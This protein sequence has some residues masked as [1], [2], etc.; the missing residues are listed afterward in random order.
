MFGFVLFQAK[1]LLTIKVPVKVFLLT[2]ILLITAGCQSTSQQKQYNFDKRQA[3]LFYY[4][5]IRT[6]PSDRRA[7][8][9]FTLEN[10]LEVVLVSDPR[11][12]SSAASLTVGTGFYDD[13]NDYQGLAHYLEH[14]VWTSS[15]KFP[16][17]NGFQQLMTENNGRTNAF[18]HPNF[19]HYFFEIDHKK[20]ALTLDMFS[21]AIN[22]PLLDKSYSKKEITAVDEEWRIAKE[23]QYYIN[24]RVNAQTSNPAHPANKFDIGNLST[25][26]D[27]DS[28]T[29]NKK[30]RAFHQKH[31][32]ADEMKLVIASKHSLDELKAF[33]NLYFS[34]FKSPIKSEDSTSST[35]SL[36]AI[37]LPQDY[38][39]HIHVKSKS[40]GE[41]L[42][43]QFP[44]EN[45]SLQWRQ[46]SNYYLY[47]LFNSEQ[48]GT[49]KHT[50]LKQGLISH[51]DIYL[52]PTTYVNSGNAVF[53]MELSE[54]GKK[55]QT[56][57]IE[58]IF[59]YINLMRS[60][61]I[62]QAYFD[63]IKKSLT[64]MW[65]ATAQP[66]I[67]D[68]VNMMSKD[69]QT[70]P[71][72]DALIHRT[73]AISFSE[74]E[75]LAI[76]QQFTPEKMRIWH[77][78]NNEKTDKELTYANGS[79][80]TSAFSPEEISTW[81]NAQVALKLP[82]VQ[83][84]R[85][86][87]T[88]VFTS[89]NRLIAEPKQVYKGASSEAWLANSQ[90][91]TDDSGFFKLQIQTP[92]ALA[93][94][95]NQVM[96]ILINRIYKRKNA[97]LKNRANELHN[98]IVEEGL[99]QFSMTEITLSNATVYHPDILSTLVYN[100]KNLTFTQ[101]ELDRE[102][103]LY[104]SEINSMPRFSPDRRIYFEF[105]RAI[106]SPSLLW[107]S[108]DHLLA[109]SQI[110][111]SDI[112]LFHQKTLK[113][114]YLNTFAFGYYNAESISDMVKESRDILGE[115]QLKELW[116]Y[117]SNFTSSP[118]NNNS[119]NTNISE[120]DVAILDNYIYPHKSKKV[121]VQLNLLN[122]LI[123]QALF[124]RL[125][126][127][128][129]MAYSVYSFQSHVHHYPSISLFLQSGNTELPTIK[130]AFDL[131]LQQYEKEL[132][133]LSP[134]TLTQM[135]NSHIQQINK[136]PHTLVSEASIFEYDW[137]N[138][139]LSFDARQLQIETLEALTKE[140]LIELYQTLFLSPQS[141]KMTLQVKGV[142]FK[143]TQ[144][145]KV[146]N[147]SASK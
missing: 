31:Y 40:V 124:K 129:E 90:F 30:L 48:P 108:E 119:F 18:T 125:R 24:K 59:S 41:W 137:F 23:K 37:H 139:N 133:Y 122:E 100:F 127:N 21:A 103:D 51:L 76:L 43:L 88:Q 13:P 62:K 104:Q 29:L 145:S 120:P 61:G 95:K 2:G 68:L 136:R 126:T 128:K 55:N 22:E 6:N 35:S 78:G 42:E 79:F 101:V 12:V 27:K 57:I 20:L 91:F 56:Q 99:N 52:D 116:K 32:R 9:T 14:M 70:I 49:L 65:H 63:Q 94:V 60:E 113:H 81:K 4:G 123:N 10:G 66:Q 16:Q 26:A 74:K 146:N 7:Y 15:K 114:N 98:V 109:L 3:P 17:I 50:L 82:P 69:L 102:I 135:I 143:D 28:A 44:L 8:E 110:N 131:F 97:P 45:N 106:K 54:L 147:I 1:T 5:D 34:D 36:A 117:Q 93:N 142:N 134:Q 86:E 115:S 112:R 111:I 140:D 71:V 73:L 138:H 132:A 72:Q 89:S 53:I 92:D 96:S 105:Q 87:K 84:A 39:Q 19:T 80:R 64:Q 33:V 25:L 141:Q 85:F 46:R 47:Q 77:Y 144:F 107:G 58:T 75:I 38:A 83:L 67:L 130:K 121:E 11:E 118:H